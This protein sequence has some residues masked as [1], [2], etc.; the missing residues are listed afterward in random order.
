MKGQP[1]AGQKGQQRAW[2][3]AERKVYY[4]VVHWAGL[5]ESRSVDQ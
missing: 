4:L 5:L 3:M 2:K 1:K